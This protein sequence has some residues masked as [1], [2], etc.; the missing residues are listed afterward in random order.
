MVARV[1][2]RQVLVQLDD[3]L[4]RRLDRLTGPM[5][6]SRSDLIRRAVNLWLDA[7]DEAEADVRYA[8]AYR[9][10]PDDL[11]D[12]AAWEALAFETWPEW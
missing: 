10:I 6:A 2:R 8:E 9:K 3:L 11:A 1:A 4:V 7:L 5:D 12:N